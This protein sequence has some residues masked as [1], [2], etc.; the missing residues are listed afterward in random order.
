MS[1]DR[2]KWDAKYGLGSHPSSEPVPL[3]LEALPRARPGRAL[4][5]ACGRGRHAIAL[6]RGGYVV[7]AIDISPVGLASARERAGD[8][9]IRWTEADLHD[10]ALETAAYQVIVWVHYTDEALVPRVLEAL[11]PGGVLVFCARPRALCRYG[12]PPGVVE[13]WFRSLRT[14]VHRETDDRVEYAGVLS[15]P[16]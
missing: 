6:A 14:L 13:G 16:D 11:A 9:A 5:L 7:D 2:A 15:S 1:G 12:P 4:D 10:Y 3:L 8:L